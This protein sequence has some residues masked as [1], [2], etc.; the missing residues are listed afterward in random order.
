MTRAISALIKIMTD[1]EAP[2]RC[3]IEATEGLLAY[4]APDEA[5]ALA[6]EFLASVFESDE[7]VTVRLDALKLMRK[8]EA[9]RISAPPVPADD[10]RQRKM[11]RR[12]AVGRRRAKLMTEGLW[13]APKG[14]DADLLDD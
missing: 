14:W 10:Y 8:A 6:K 1:S 9:R 3:R 5:V 7:H 4:E 13:P 11:Q 2:L 12:I